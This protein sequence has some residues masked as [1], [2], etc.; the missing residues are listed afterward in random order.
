MFQANIGDYPVMGTL[1][2]ENS[3]LVG[4]DYVFEIETGQGKSY[5][6]AY[7]QVKSLLSEQYGQPADELE[8]LTA[9]YRG[10]SPQSEKAD[11]G[12][13]HGSGYYRSQWRFDDGPRTM[14][15]RL[16]GKDGALQLV[17]RHFRSGSRVQQDHTLP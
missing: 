14:T 12:I 15:L 4:C 8:Y 3:A 5:S 9:T 17:Y 2:F 10:S 7:F 11:L 6:K 1:E 16:S 13:K